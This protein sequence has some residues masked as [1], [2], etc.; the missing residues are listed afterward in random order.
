MA[1]ITGVHC[2]DQPSNSLDPVCLSKLLELVNHPNFRANGYNEA[3]PVQ[4]VVGIVSCVITVLPCVD[5][6]DGRRPDSARIENAE[7]IGKTL[8]GVGLTDEPERDR[9]VQVAEDGS[10]H[11]RRGRRRSGDDKVFKVQSQLTDV[12]MTFANL[13]FALSDF[14]AVGLDVSAIFAARLPATGSDYKF[15]LCN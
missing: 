3:P 4:Y 8:T 5:S 9:L 13:H 11:R 15:I 14:A 12:R 10:G 1:T 2:S 6:A 7:R